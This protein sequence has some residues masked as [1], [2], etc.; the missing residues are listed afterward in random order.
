MIIK[1]LLRGAKGKSTKHWVTGENSSILRVMKINNKKLEN[2]EFF[3][4][5]ESKSLIE[6]FQILDGFK[7]LLT[8]PVKEQKEDNSAHLLSVKKKKDYN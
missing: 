6:T 4:Q 3:I 7:N 2:L 8:P 1:K 5:F